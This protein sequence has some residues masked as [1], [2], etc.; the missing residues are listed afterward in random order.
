MHET[1]GKA[2]HFFYEMDLGR[3]KQK[4]WE[5]LHKTT[6]KPPLTHVPGNFRTSSGP[7]GPPTLPSCPAPSTGL[8]QESPA[9]P[10]PKTTESCVTAAPQ[11][12]PAPHPSSTPGPAR[13]PEE[14]RAGGGAAAAT[15]SLSLRAELPTPGAAAAEGGR[16][17]REGDPGP[18]PPEAAR[19]VLFPRVCLSE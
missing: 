8:T 10:S 19:R 13:P 17:R 18:E 3:E 11:D 16:D 7:T 1:K 12:R 14:R 9:G 15:T 2:L 5:N 6:E 4:H